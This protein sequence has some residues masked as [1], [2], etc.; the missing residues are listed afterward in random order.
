M[1]E[2]AKQIS[3]FGILT[4]VIGT[5][6]TLFITNALDTIGAVDVIVERLDNLGD[7]IYERLK[8]LDKQL[9]IFHERLK[10]LGLPQ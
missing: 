4:L 8:E 5:V 2:N 3:W 1:S 10:Y 6:L 7:T 9:E